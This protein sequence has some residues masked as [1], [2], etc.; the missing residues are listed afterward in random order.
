[1]HLLFYT[2]SYRLL[3]SVHFPLELA[4]GYAIELFLAIL[5]IMFIQILNHSSLETE[6]TPVQSTAMVVKLVSMLVFF[7]EVFI[8]IWEI[9]LNRKMRKLRIEGFQK[10]SEEN[11][12]SNYSK[13]Y[14]ACG[15]LAFVA[16][17]AIL[18]LGFVVFQSRQ[19]MLKEILL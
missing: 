2:G 12:R 7:I 4:V 15:C 16:Y 13:R 10:I 6:L 1:M 9:V 8:M 11:R 14:S 5:P 3:P 17:I 18:V 19:A